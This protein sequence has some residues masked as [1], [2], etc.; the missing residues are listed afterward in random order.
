MTFKEFIKN[1]NCRVQFLLTYINI[2]RYI[3]MIHVS[4]SVGWVLGLK[5]SNYQFQLIKV[6][7]KFGPIF[8]ISFR[9]RIKIYFFEEL[10]PKLD[11]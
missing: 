10:N 8:G 5:G 2:T 7:S 9:T 3:I 1:K 11:T 6:K 4:T